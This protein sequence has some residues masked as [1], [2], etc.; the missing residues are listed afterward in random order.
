[1]QFFRQTRGLFIFSEEDSE[2][3]F[4][5]VKETGFYDCDI[6]LIFTA[7]DLDLDLNGLVLVAFDLGLIPFYILFAEKLKIDIVTACVLLNGIIGFD[8][9]FRA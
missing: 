2:P 8:V 3:N 9:I 6:L 1:M 4:K 5:R 7:A